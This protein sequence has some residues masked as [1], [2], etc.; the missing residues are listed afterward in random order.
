MRI[1]DP[2]VEL[3]EKYEASVSTKPTT[4]MND[5]EKA[6]RKIEADEVARRKAAAETSAP[7]F[8]SGEFCW[9]VGV[10][11]DRPVLFVAR[12]HDRAEVRTP[13]G[14]DGASRIEV[15]IRRLRKAS[16]L[17]PVCHITRFDGRECCV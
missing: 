16:T 10:E 17:C 6:F 8:K 3:R 2:Y 9:L 15:K 14:F 11:G 1:G 7:E 12:W 4:P 5:A 13:D